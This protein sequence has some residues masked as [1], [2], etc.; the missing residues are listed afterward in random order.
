QYSDITGHKNP[1]HI[2][3]LYK[4]EFYSLLGKYFSQV[5]MMGQQSGM[6]SAI[7]S[8]EKDNSNEL[9]WTSGSPEKLVT[10][11]QSPGI[12]LIALASDADIEIKSIQLFKDPAY[13]EQQYKRQAESVANSTTYKTGHIIL[14]PVRWI[15]SAFQRKK[16]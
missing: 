16:K 14:A 11:P 10:V 7:F 15:R 2:K 5:K 6:M 3:E 9:S 12:Y 13:S 1:F 8:L 4:E